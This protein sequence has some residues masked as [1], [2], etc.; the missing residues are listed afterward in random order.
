MNELTGSVV[1]SNDL[2]NFV[3]ASFYLNNWAYVQSNNSYSCLDAVFRDSPTN[4]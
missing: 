2:K 4:Y 3:V 1:N